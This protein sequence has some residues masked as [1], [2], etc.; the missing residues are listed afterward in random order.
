MLTISDKIKNM[1]MDTRAEMVGHRIGE[2]VAPRVRKA[3]KIGGYMAQTAGAKSRHK[4]GEW[5]GKL[6]EKSIDLGGQALNAIAPL[7]TIE[8]DSYMA[9]IAAGLDD[10]IPFN[11]RHMSALIDAYGIHHG[12]EDGRFR[13]ISSNGTEEL[14][15]HVSREKDGA[16][17]V[18]CEGVFPYKG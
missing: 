18:T 7:S 17:R 13:A 3:Q 2:H 4:L 1:S 6:V 11:P 10:S 8:Y 14:S 5:G 16:F 9:H 12:V 15:F